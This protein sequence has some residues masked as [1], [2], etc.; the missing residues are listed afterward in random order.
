V[1]AWHLEL[2]GGWGEVGGGGSQVPFAQQSLSFW[3]GS[4]L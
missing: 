4:V 2:V 1:Q 3:L